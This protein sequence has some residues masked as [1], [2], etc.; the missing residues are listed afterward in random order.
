[1][2]EAW[3]K[4][5]DGGGEEWKRKKNNVARRFGRKTGKAKRRGGSLKTS[6]LPVEK[7]G[8]LGDP[9]FQSSECSDPDD[10]S[11][12]I[13]N[14]PDYRTAEVRS[15]LDALDIK[16]Q[17]EK[18]RTG[19][20]VFTQFEYRKTNISVQ[21]LKT[22]D[23]KVPKWAV[24]PEWIKAE[25]NENLERRSRPFINSRETAIPQ[26]DLVKNFLHEYESKERMYLSTS[27]DLD[28]PAPEPLREA[29]PK[30]LPAPALAPLPAPLPSTPNPPPAPGP[31]RPTVSIAYPGH[32]SVPPPGPSAAPSSLL[33][34]HTQT[35]AP[36]LP[37]GLTS[38]PVST[39]PSHP[40]FLPYSIANPPTQDTN[41][42]LPP[43]G[44]TYGYGK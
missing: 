6:G 27:A 18:L 20:Q 32:T 30:S 22:F 34:A 2:R 19:N 44:Y 4:G 39:F 12:C 26:F 13:I 17:L 28:K 29:A 7:F 38:A 14:D 1:M 5:R 21:K 36:I 3:K 31:S 16:H 41:H 23:S 9:G 25:E 35:G 33:Y 10:K 43:P 37:P 42:P 11:R 40:S 8:F 24:E 15:I